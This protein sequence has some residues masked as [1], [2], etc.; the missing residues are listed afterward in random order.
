LTSYIRKYVK[1]RGAELREKI[2]F[3]VIEGLTIF[4]VPVLMVKDVMPAIF[5]RAIGAP[6]RLI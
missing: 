4:I 6:A 1:E 3:N 5:V 2:G